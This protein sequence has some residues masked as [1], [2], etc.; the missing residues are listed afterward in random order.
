MDYK[1]VQYSLIQTI[2]PPGWRWSFQYIGHEFSGSNRT[3][4]E[5]FRAVQQAID[6]LM[7]LKL[8]VHE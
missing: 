3:R 5:A 6:N 1:G 4:P 2:A 7:Q 8:T